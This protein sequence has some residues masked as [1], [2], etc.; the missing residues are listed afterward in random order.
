M[1]LKALF[2]LIAFMFAGVIQTCEASRTHH[3]PDY[4]ADDESTLP[5]KKRWKK[6]TLQDQERAV[7]LRALA[8]Q[9]GDSKEFNL[10]HILSFSDWTNDEL[11]DLLSKKSLKDCFKEG[12]SYWRLDQ[13][14]K[15][16]EDDVT[17]LSIERLTPLIPPSIQNLCQLRELK[18][19]N[20]GLIVLPSCLPNLTK[21]EKLELNGNKLKRIPDSIGRL[22]NLSA[23]WIYNNSLR[24][25]PTELL[26]LPHL[27]TIW[28]SGISLATE[29]AEPP[30]NQMIPYADAIRGER[31]HLSIRGLTTPI[32]GNILDANGLEIVAKLRQKNCHVLYHHGH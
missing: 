3:S 16:E 28:I 24:T 23:L 32:V 7:L 1:R 4:D 26:D 11:T 31:A 6:A 30:A 27:S 21:L 15:H 2:L 25:L 12:S 19:W 9:T 22:L 10:N 20:A 8:Q 17:T 29:P 14:I 18:I 5:P 13:K